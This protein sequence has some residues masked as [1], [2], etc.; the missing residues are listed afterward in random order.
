M[1]STSHPQISPAI[2]AGT[3]SIEKLIAEVVDNAL[4]QT[5]SELAKF[6]AETTAL[7]TEIQT[8]SIFP[9]F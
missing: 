6:Q 9:K 8:V 5:R 4:K 7:K 2:Q 3:Q 1:A